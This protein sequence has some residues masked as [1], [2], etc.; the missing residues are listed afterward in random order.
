MQING[1]NEFFS[2]IAS[3][4]GAGA[5]RLNSFLPALIPQ[6][7]AGHDTLFLSDIG[8]RLSFNVNKAPLLDGKQKTD[9]IT[10]PLLQL[11]DRNMARVEGIL[12]EMH[13]LAIAA[14]D[15]KLS[16]LERLNMQVEF[17][18]LREQLSV[19]PRN[20]LAQSRGQPTVSREPTLFDSV[21]NPEIFSNDTFT[22]GNGT[23]LFDRMR[24]RIINGEKWNVRE[25]YAHKTFSTDAGIVEG[26]KWHVIDDSNKNILQKEFDIDENGVFF[27]AKPSDTGKVVRT[28]R[29]ELE[30]YTPVILM[31]AKSAAEGAELIEQ[32]INRV[33]KWRSNIA[34]ISASREKGVTT[35]PDPVDVLYMAY[36]FFKKHPLLGYGPD[37]IGGGSESFLLA[38]GV[39]NEKYMEF[40]G[41]IKADVNAGFSL[42][43]MSDAKQI[44]NDAVASSLFY[45][46][47]IL[48]EARIDTIAS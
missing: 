36:N 38:D 37:S 17:E 47:N 6:G 25:V 34:E 14:Q 26:G 16:D 48:T 13:E 11:V 29:E 43:A 40:D 5:G 42:K 10:D 2:R 27:K 33:Q 4:N 7:Q 20:L 18:E 22:R 12:K 45:R 30:L 44:K 39:H 8:K 19:M 1:L 3:L 31:D 41:L 15:T 23:N 9:R 46:N 28:V 35:G 32:Q 24:E 21:R